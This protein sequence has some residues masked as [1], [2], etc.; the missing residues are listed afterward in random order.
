MG[1]F[2]SQSLSFPI[3]K[4]ARA[5]ILFLGVVE[6]TIP[7]FL[8]EVRQWCLR[9]ST[10][11][12]SGMAYTTHQPAVTQ[13]GASESSLLNKIPH[14]L[15]QSVLDLHS[16]VMLCMHWLWRTRNMGDPTDPSLQTDLGSQQCSAV[17]TRCCRGLEG[18]QA[19]LFYWSEIPVVSTHGLEL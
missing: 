13:Q 1:D 8:W 14:K 19:H 18:H 6:M 15:L 2:T 11:W 5:T 4:M 10:V 3:C 17:G 16:H 9:I 7:R 12:T